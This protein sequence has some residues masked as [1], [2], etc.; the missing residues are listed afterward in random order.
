[1]AKLFHFSPAA[2]P[3]KSSP[4]TVI[5]LGRF[6]LAL[7]RELTSYGVEVFGID[8]SEKLVREHAQDCTDF[9]VADTTDPQALIQLGVDEATCVVIGIGTDLEASIL[10]ASNVLEFGVPD[11]WAKATSDAHAKILTQIGV[12]HVIRPERDTGRRVAHL[13]GG[14]FE[15]FA[16]VDSDYGMIKLAAPQV[17]IGKAVTNVE[18]WK[19][20]NV[21]VVAVKSPASEWRPFRE[22]M[23]LHSSDL[24]IIAGS[25]TRL[26]AFSQE[27]QPEK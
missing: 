9:A 7:S 15:N 4:V 13:L 2:Q 26:E 17:L 21:Q 6:G 19:R 3:L 14:R 22:S 16:E 11:I 10:T 8:S 27:L 25:P 23:V 24:I 12:H 20:R 5:G 18:L 1:M